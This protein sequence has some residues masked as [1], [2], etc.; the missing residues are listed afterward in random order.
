MDYMIAIAGFVVALAVTALATPLVRQIALARGWVDQPDGQRKLHAAPIPAIGGIA[1]AIG[2]AVAALFCF[3]AQYYLPIEGLTASPMFWACGLIMVGT[4]LYDDLRGLGFKSKFMV[5]VAVAYLLLHAGY[6]VD[7]SALPFLNGDAYDLALISIPVTILWVVGV[8][9]AVNLLDGLD[10]L[11]A[12][13]AL[14]AFASLG[15]VFG[16]HG[17]VGMV[18]LSVLICGALVGFLAY[19]FNPA[20]IFMGDSGSLLLGYLLAAFSLAGRGHAD[21]ALALLVPVVALGLPLTDTGLSVVRRFRERRAIFAPDRDHI[22]HRMAKRFPHRRAVLLLYA[23]AV[24][25]GVAAAFISVLP[26]AQALGVVA[27]TGAVAVAG[28]IGL[29]YHQVSV[30]EAVPAEEPVVEAE[31]EHELAVAPAVVPV[32]SSGD[33]SASAADHI[34]LHARTPGEAGPTGDGTASLVP[35]QGAWE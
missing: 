30:P 29:G 6:R 26:L 4:G 12:G 35:A 33:G 28:L 11:A 16:I 1:I 15:V 2:F 20:S 17:D 7:L 27:L 18:L 9:N 31:P 10:G 21:P 23:A 19:N 13:V 34:V 5:Q 8:I 24:G 25:F 32:A 22:H 3:G 14:I